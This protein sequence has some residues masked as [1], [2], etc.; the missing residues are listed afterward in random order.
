MTNYRNA[1][2]PENL[3]LLATVASEGSLACCRPSTGP[4]AQRAHLPVYGQMEEQL[5]VLLVDRSSR[6]AQLTPAGHALKDASAHLLTE[7][8]SVAL[9][10][11]RV[12]TGWEAQLVIVA[13]DVINKTPL[14]ELLDAFYPARC[15]DAYQVASGNTQR[16]HRVAHQRRLGLG[17]RQSCQRRHSSQGFDMPRSAMCHLCSPSPSTTH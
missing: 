11:K 15:A 8:E 16:H 12:A 14:L 5:D 9:R 1:L 3:H 7:L 6:R 13:D 4:G 17:A 10:V 2:S